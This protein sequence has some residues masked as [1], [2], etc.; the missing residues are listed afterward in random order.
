MGNI[1]FKSVIEGGAVTRIL[2]EAGLK[3]AKF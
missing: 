1:F 3:L 2:L